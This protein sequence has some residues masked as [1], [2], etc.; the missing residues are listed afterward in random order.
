[1]KKN[2]ILLLFFS[3]YCLSEAQT[4]WDLFPKNQKTWWQTSDKSLQLLYNDSTESIGSDVRIHYFGEKYIAGH[5]GYC[6]LDLLINPPLT[7]PFEPP[8]E[9]F[10]PM[11]SKNGNWHFEDTSEPVIFHSQYMPGESWSFP[12]TTV[13]T[14]YTQVKIE[15]IGMDTIQVFGNT[16]AAKYFRMNTLPNSNHPLNGFVFTLTEKFG[17]THYVSLT[18]LKNGQSSPVYDIAGFEKNG[19]AYGTVPSFLSF[20]G[21]YAPG[22]LYKWKSKSVDY[23]L[24]R[25]INQWWLDSITAVSITPDTVLVTASRTLLKVTTLTQNGQTII[26]TS[27]STLPEVISTYTKKYYEPMLVATPNW[28]SPGNTYSALLLESKGTF[29]DDGKLSISVSFYKAGFNALNCSMGVI[30][31]VSEGASVHEQFGLTGTSSALEGGYNYATLIGNRQNGVVWGDI[32][33][34]PTVLVSDPIYQ[35]VLGM[36]PNPSS[37][38]LILNIPES[39]E[40]Y[41]LKVID[42]Q[43]KIVESRANFTGSTLDISVLQR[44]VYFI[45]VLGRDRVYVGKVLKW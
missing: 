3:N 24:N 8:I 12:V 43:G 13:D 34:L 30:T 27:I 2:L 16:T 21:H 14:Q 37:G 19:A 39:I 41:R 22:D 31:G 18:S 5:F 44:G 42:L 45:H 40:G 29:G 11:V 10:N 4:N 26:D 28:Y 15:C 17:F 1:M 20:F 9:Y 6:F 36:S 38:I 32:N 25:T 23:A 7:I 33:P 35:F